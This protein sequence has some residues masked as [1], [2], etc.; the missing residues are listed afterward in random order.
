[1]TFIM[2]SRR[3]REKGIKGN[4]GLIKEGQTGGTIHFQSER[5]PV[6]THARKAKAAAGRKCRHQGERT[7]KIQR[8]RWVFW[9]VSSRVAGGT[10]QPSFL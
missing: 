2:H 4:E 8:L 7:P 6:G 1:M 5:S 10:L 3:R 9:Q